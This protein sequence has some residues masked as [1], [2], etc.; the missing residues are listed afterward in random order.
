MS[1]DRGAAVAGMQLDAD[2][3]DAPGQVDQLA[4]LARRTA[5]ADLDAVDPHVELVRVEGRLRRADRREDASP[6]RVVAEQR[7]LEQ[8]V[9]GDRPADVDRVVLARGAADLDGHL[10]GGPLGIGDQLPREIG[11]HFGDNRGELGR[12][13]LH[14]GCAVGQQDHGVVRRRAAVAVDAVE[15]RAGRRAQR[16]VHSGRIGRGVGGEHAQHRRQA[17][18]E[19][20]RSLR[21]AADRPAV[22]VH[23]GGLLRDRV[24]GADRVRGV[25]SPGVAQR[26]GGRVDSGEQRVDR[27]PLADEPGGADRDLAGTDAEHFADAFGRGMRVS[28]AG[29][30]GARVRAPRVEHDRP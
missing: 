21:H 14:A 2:L 6:V 5:P 25:R 19:H 1:S 22:G 30:A 18:G 7:A 28:E 8:V 24:G 20:A 16:S 12:A 26:V 10:L 27:Q 17:R 3:H 23:D 13:R 9:A 11:A 4:R 15:R 29:R